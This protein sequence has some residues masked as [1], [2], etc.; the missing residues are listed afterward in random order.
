[1]RKETAKRH[2][3]AA[4]VGHGYSH[5]EFA[6]AA[7][8]F[9]FDRSDLGVPWYRFVVCS[10]DAPPIRSELGLTMGGVQGL[11]ALRRADTIIV[12][13]T[14]RADEPSVE[15]LDA[16]RHAHA[17]GARLLSFCT[18]AFVLAATGLLD[19]KRATTHWMHTREFA[20]RFPLVKVD[21]DVLYIDE[22]DVLTSAGT[23]GAIDLSLYVVRRDFGAEVAN[24]VARR[25]VV[26]PHRDGGQAQYIQAPLPR[27]ED[28]LLGETLA[29]LEANLQD[30]VT[31]GELAQRA[32]MSVRTFAR[33]FHGA[34]G[35]TPHQW[36]LR[37]RI[38]RAQRLLETTD[39]PVEAVAEGA[40]FG[41]AA[42][43]RLH[44]QRHVHT[45]PLG[46]RKTFRQRAEVAAPGDAA[47]S[48]S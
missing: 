5:F 24:A 36:V 25:M 7:E 11:D 29:W 38:L 3:V 47:W 33:R 14:G 43:L 20:M 42:N 41:T 35:T 4:V 10:A 22:G 15:L 46:Y 44:F 34:T 23:A 30:D 1:M 8:V 39:L 16:L 18:G 13:V 9:G 12:P 31:V 32:A 45:T 48:T 37:Q 17:R 21:P 6:V 27:D 40:G 19:G 26:P 28:D 2:T